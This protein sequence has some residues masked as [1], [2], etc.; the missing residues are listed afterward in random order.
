M[1]VLLPAESARRKGK[2][3]MTVF[4]WQFHWTSLAARHSPPS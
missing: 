2:T 3:S 4:G 1:F